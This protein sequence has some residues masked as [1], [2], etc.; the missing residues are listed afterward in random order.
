MQIKDN[1]VGRQVSAGIN[2]NK[3]SKHI[4]HGM[5][6][7][8]DRVTLFNNTKKGNLYIQVQDNMDEQEEPS[9]TTVNITF[10]NEAAGI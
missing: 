6:I 5:K 4:S 2:A 10:N 7:T 8:D 3:P 1:G 9:G